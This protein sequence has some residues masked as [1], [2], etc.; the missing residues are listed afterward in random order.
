MVDFRA[1][2]NTETRKPASVSL[3]RHFRRVQQIALNTKETVIAAVI[4]REALA[5]LPLIDA[6]IL[7]ILCTRVL[8]KVRMLRLFSF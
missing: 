1:E 4:F 8:F 5:Y 2:R 3:S 7:R 6:E